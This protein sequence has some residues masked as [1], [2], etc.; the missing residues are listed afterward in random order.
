M[1]TFLIR[2]LI[3]AIPLIIIVTFITKALLVLSPGNYLDM[4]RGNPLITKE[5]LDQMERLYH[6]DSHNVLERYW[7][8]LW[9]ALHGDLG[10][11][12]VKSASVFT[13]LGERVLN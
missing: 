12:Y 5:Y 2:R 8:W 1:R 4:I 7:Y 13:L 6:L 3:A 10:Y 11:S 9:P